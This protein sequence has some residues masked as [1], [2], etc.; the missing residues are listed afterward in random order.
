MMSMHS[1]LGLKGRTE[2]AP[3]HRRRPSIFVSEL[4]ARQNSRGSATL[5][6]TM[7]PKA[8]SARKCTVS[9]IGKCFAEDQ[10]IAN[11]ATARLDRHPAVHEL[12]TFEATDPTPLEGRSPFL[13][14]HR[15]RERAR[16]ELDQPEG[17]R[18]QR[19]V[20]RSRRDPMSSA[21]SVQVMRRRAKRKVEL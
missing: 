14:R 2:R 20:G 17:S 10:P 19:C 11:C 5:K 8:S 21:A 12:T 9:V 6:F 1:A 16:R 13:E 18:Q 15:R 4:R 3:A 7:S